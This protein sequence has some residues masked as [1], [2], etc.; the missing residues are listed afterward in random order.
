MS[1]AKI[2][3]RNKKDF[4]IQIKIPYG[5][6]MLEAEEEIQRCIN[7]AGSLGTGEVLEQFD[8]DG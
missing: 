4:T 7:E 1:A 8:T 6:S 2:I 3:D 5:K